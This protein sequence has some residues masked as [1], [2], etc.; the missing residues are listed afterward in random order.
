MEVIEFIA[1]I[2]GVNVMLRWIFVKFTKGRLKLRYY[3]VINKS[4]D[5]AL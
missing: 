1:K 2:R 3:Q 4:Y 5:N